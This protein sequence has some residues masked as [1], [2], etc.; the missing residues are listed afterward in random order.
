[1]AVE[2]TGRVE[3]NGVERERER[4]GRRGFWDE[5][6]N[7]AGW[8]DIFRFKNIRNGF[9]PEPLLIVLESRPNQF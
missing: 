3:S 1:M 9:K 7:D 4:S 6:Q 8:F 2:E 5:N